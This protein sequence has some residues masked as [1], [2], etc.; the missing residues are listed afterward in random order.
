MNRNNS[1][2]K[3]SRTYTLLIGGMMIISSQASGTELNLANEPLSVITSADPNII[4]AIDDSGSMDFEVL[5]PTNDG[6]IYWNTATE[7]FV[8]AEE[9]GKVNFYT[10]SSQ[11]YTY[12]F[13]NGTGD[14]NRVTTTRFEIP[15]FPQYAFA[16]SA[17]YNKAY[18]DPMVTYEPWTSFG[19]TVFADIDP[20][21]APSDPRVPGSERHDLTVLSARTDPY[22]SFSLRAGMVIP[23]DTEYAAEGSSSWQIAGSDI[24]LTADSNY[25]LKYYPA[26]YYVVT[27]TGTYSV[28]YGGDDDDD[29]DD[30][31]GITVNGTC[32]SPNVTHYT[33]LERRPSSFSGSAGVDA[34]GPDGQCLSKVE[35]QPT[36]AEMQNFANWFSYYRK[37]HLALRAGMGAAFNDLSSVRVGWFPI[38]DLRDVNML[39]M[40]NERNNLL[41]QLYDIIGN[42]GSTPNREALDHAGR[43]YKRSDSSA[44]ITAS[45]QKNFTLQ[46]TDGYSS[47]SNSPS[48]GNVDGTKGVPYQDGFSDTL[49]DIA[50]NYYTENLR[51]SL[52]AG[53]VPVPAGCSDPT[54][55]P[56]LDCN[57][58]PHMNTYTVGL[59]TL[60]F[61]FGVTHDTVADTYTNSPTWPD[62]NVAKNPAQID[63]LYH[64]AVNGRGDIF[65]ADT[66]FELRNS[67][68]AALR[69][70]VANVGSGASTE[71]NAGAVHSGSQ[72]Y[73][74]LFQG[75][76][77]TGELRALAL[78]D[79]SGNNGCNTADPPGSVCPIA[80]WEAHSL[81]DTVANPVSARKM[82]TFDG[83]TGVAF[84]WG[85][86]SIAQQN[87][88]NLDATG[89]VD[90]LGQDRVNYLRGERAQEEN[91]G[92]SFRNRKSLLGDIVHSSPLFVE[93]P[94]RLYPATWNDNLGGSTPETS[95]D[96]FKTTHQNRTP[97]VYVGANDGF[98]HAFQADDS[99]GA[100]T[101]LLAYMPSKA[102]ENARFLT[103]PTYTHRYYV[104]GAPVENDV[105][106]NGAWHTVLVGGLGVGGQGIYALDIT[107]PASFS[108]A[109][110]GS[111]VLWEFTDTDDDNLGYTVGRPSIVRLHNG[112]WAT[113]VGNG[114]NNTEADG[115]DSST[116]NAMLYIL[117]MEGSGNDGTW[118]SATDYVRLDTKDGKAEDPL[119][120]NR[121]NGLASII[122]IDKDG[123]LITDYVYGGDLFGN[124]WRF[125]LTSTSAADWKVSAYSGTATDPDPLFRARDPASG[126]QPQPITTGIRV[127][128]HPNGI[129]HGVMVYFGTGKYLEV[130]DQAPNTNLT[131]SFYSIWDNNFPTDPNSS[132]SVLSGLADPNG[133]DSYVER[134]QLQQQQI[135]AED[136]TADNA[137]RRVTDHEVNYTSTGTTEHGWYL[138]LKPSSGS[139]EGE[140]VISDPV[141]RGKAVVFTTFIPNANECVPG[142][143]GYLMVLDR[144]SGGRLQQSP[145][146]VNNSLTFDH[147]DKLG[148]GDTGTEIASG[149]K[150]DK[151]GNTPTFVFSK[152]KNRDREMALIQEQQTEDGTGTGGTNDDGINDMLL[153]TGLPNTGRQT[154]RQLR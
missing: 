80:A 149:I 119:N 57:T 4:L 24:T 153:N 91:N 34:L 45:C 122:P 98:L 133:T 70:I 10:S 69:G 116:G 143:Y 94:L 114:Y 46:F 121:P 28:K 22:W 118:N 18:Y 105:F 50:M 54:P 127:G 139:N 15:S 35:I 85:D 88:L 60:G 135:D 99:A 152:A 63:D 56:R 21:D 75:S 108:E 39:D 36:N 92:G 97:V 147:S 109:N 140:M 53:D 65:N 43:Q 13:P 107:N 5:F 138:D 29:D 104:D 106:Y 11:K 110:A 51:P 62:V 125:D 27:D 16:R 58:N 7:S 148:F 33:Y 111:L 26:T 73:Q 141:L 86:L 68:K 102:L 32:N 134:T 72:V 3:L 130:G 14:G 96:A 52:P 83:S 38:N 19:T 128:A 78:H 154:W 9:A 31:S 25:G 120:Q 89:A 64:A 144:G 30:D 6:G 77:W 150:L 79:G 101:E 103:Y 74:A 90:A 2:T 44:P 61:I 55:D 49:G 151:G 1:H 132:I 93:A 112:K 12:L 47:L 124:V 145:F 126:N 146:D 37:R 23:K 82:I 117:F 41:N 136:S 95:Y 42:S 84:N 131:Q 123:D 100:G 76:R 66:P 142:G 59:G 71:V 8:G 17:A 113:I 87:S 40:D 137:Y 20:A 48:V 81:L 67:L 115:A 129:N